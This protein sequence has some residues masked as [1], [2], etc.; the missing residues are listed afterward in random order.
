VQAS[1]EEPRFMTIAIELCPYGSVDLLVL[2]AFHA[3]EPELNVAT[4]EAMALTAAYIQPVKLPIAFGASTYLA[5][6]RL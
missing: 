1:P 3:V 5:P 2:V 4:S 6:E